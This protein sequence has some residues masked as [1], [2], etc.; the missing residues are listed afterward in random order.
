VG[1]ILDSITFSVNEGEKVAVIGPVGCGKSTLMKLLCGIL[2]RDSGELRIGAAGMPRALPEW[3]SDTTGYV[4][5]EPL[6]FSGSVRENIAFGT[7]GEGLKISEEK[8][9]AVLGVAQIDEEVKLMPAGTDT[10]LGQRGSTVSGG[11]KQRLAIARAL[12][13]EPKILLLDDITASLDA[14]NEER[15]MAAL[16]SWSRDLTCFI[17][18][19]RLSTLQHVDKIMFMDSGKILGF[20][21]HEELM[22]STPAYAAFIAEHSGSIRGP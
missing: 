5:Q 6:L 15:L 17:V 22:L 3:A 14:A 8:L 19:Q 2:H 20:G 18:S 12:A 21:R 13:R 16:S 1:R 7:R 11:Q 10:V 4:P 9:M